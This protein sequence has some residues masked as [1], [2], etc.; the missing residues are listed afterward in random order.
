MISA[1]GTLSSMARGFAH[2]VV[3]ALSVIKTLTDVTS[4]LMGT[5]RSHV[6]N[7]RL[8]CLA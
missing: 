2:T 8:L 4:S 7:A 1:T 6:N 5:V 3:M